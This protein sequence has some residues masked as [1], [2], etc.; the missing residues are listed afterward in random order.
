M[1]SMMP[2]SMLPCLSPLHFPEVRPCTVLAQKIKQRN[3][4][5]DSRSSCRRGSGNQRPQFDKAGDCK[6]QAQRLPNNCRHCVFF[7]EQ[8]LQDH[9]AGGASACDEKFYDPMKTSAAQYG[10]CCKHGCKA[11]P[12][13]HDPLRTPNLLKQPCSS[14]TNWG[15]PAN[16]NSTSK[17]RSSD[18]HKL[19]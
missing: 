14:T 11:Y 4:V 9:R 19:A 3:A 6:P 13:D 18:L 10:G 7:R 16:S 8:L 5:L 1:L 17:I 12:L 15:P 2:L